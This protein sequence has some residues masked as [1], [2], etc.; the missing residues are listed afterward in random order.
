MKVRPFHHQRP[1]A[2]C[3]LCYGAGVFFGVYLPYE[4]RLVWMG[5]ILCVFG[6]VLLHRMHK[7]QVLGWM[8]AFLFLGLLLS[9]H[10]SHPQLP[11]PGRYTITG[12]VAEE[13]TLRPDG[14][15]QGYLEQTVR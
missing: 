12:V 15:A 14:S 10:A 6:C 1:L 4:P 9:G 7:R 13:L 8:G 5:L 2:A 11:Q 3:A